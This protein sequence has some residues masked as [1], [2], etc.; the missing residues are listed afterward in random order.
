MRRIVAPGP[1]GR[2]RARRTKAARATGELTV[3]RSVDVCKRAE[4]GAP[5]ADG[6]GLVADGALP[7]VAADNNKNKR[8]RHG[9]SKSA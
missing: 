9:C 4:G 2:G 7:V 5:P 1:G 6:H 8:P 3:C